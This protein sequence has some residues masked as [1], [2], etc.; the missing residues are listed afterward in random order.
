VFVPRGGI[1]YA[2]TFLLSAVL[3]NLMTTIVIISLMKK[4]SGSQRDR[5]FLPQ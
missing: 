5:V 4:L 1:A 2:A 3:D